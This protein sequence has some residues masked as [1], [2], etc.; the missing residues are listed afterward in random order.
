MYILLRM[1]IFDA[2]LNLTDATSDRERGTGVH[3]GL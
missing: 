2:T 3:L 1:M